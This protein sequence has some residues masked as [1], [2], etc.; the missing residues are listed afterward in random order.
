[1]VLKEIRTALKQIGYDVNY[2]NQEKIIPEK[3]AVVLISDIN[4]EV[5]SNTSYKVVWEIS[6]LIPFLSSE[7]LMNKL[8]D[9]V[10]SLHE[11]VSAITF[12]LGKPRVD[13]EGNLLI[14]NLICEY[15][16][17]INIE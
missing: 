2:S 10:I 6:I 1:M 9:I 17:V 13:V 12:K 14:L 11:N 15:W 7:S 5:E 8:S 3:E 16:E 4:L